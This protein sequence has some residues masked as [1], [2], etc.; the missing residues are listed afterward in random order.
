MNIYDPTI[1][2]DPL[3]WENSNSRVSSFVTKAEH[4]ANNKRRGEPYLEKY[5][6]LGE[7][8][9]KTSEIIYID[10]PGLEKFENK[11]ILVIGAGPTTNWYDWDPNKY[12][13][14]FSCNHFFLNKKIQGIKIDLAIIGSEVDIERKEFVDYVSKNETIIGL[15][16]YQ[17]PVDKVKR[18][19]SKI[20]N[21]FFPFVIRFQGKI[22][23]AP[24]LIVLATLLGASHVDYVGVDGLP[25]GYKKGDES[26]HSF[27]PLKRITVDHPYEMTNNHYKCLKKYLKEIRLA[28]HF[29]G[30]DVVYNNLGEGHEQNVMS[31]LR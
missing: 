6:F 11:K 12:D 29:Q 4:F 18:L 28:T 13:Y 7:K 26:E 25:K 20:N 27:Q 3:N 22:G 23:V 17:Q 2:S 19:Q 5:K 10:T 14:I 9:I 1:F 15:E 24:K 30:K 21:T 31:T 16:D 8:I